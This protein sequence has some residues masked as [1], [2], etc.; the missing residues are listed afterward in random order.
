MP[1]VDRVEEHA[2]V[3][4]ERALG[5]GAYGSGANR[6]ACAERTEAPIDLVSPL[7]RPADPEVDKSAFAI[8]WE[9]QSATCPTGQAAYASAIL[10]Q[11]GRLVLKFAFPRP[12]CET[13][14]L[15]DR[16]VHSKEN[17]RSLTTSPYETYLRAARD[18]QETEA[19]QLLYRK[20]CRVEGKQSELVSHGLRETRYLGEDKRQFQR[21]WTAAAVNL[22][23]LFK[24]AETRKVS[25]ETALRSLNAGQRQTLPA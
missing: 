21:L 4:V 10:E 1:T 19:F 7:R 18:R 8:D 6:A 5:D 15:F 20:R 9:A 13:C 3:E 14:R 17:G 2:G 23:R 11:A 22:K 16:C 25:L 12:D 24:L